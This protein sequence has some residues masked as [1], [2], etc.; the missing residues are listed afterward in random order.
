[1]ADLAGVRAADGGEEV[2]ED[3][4]RLEKVELAVELD[5][6]RREQVPAE[7]GHRHVVVPE[8]ALIRQIVDRED[9]GELAEARRVAVERAEVDGDEA[10]LPV[11][12]VNDLWPPGAPPRLPDQRQ[13]FE[14]AAAE[15]DK[16][17]AVVPVVAVGRPVEALAVE[18]LVVTEKVHGN[19]RGRPALEE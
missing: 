6:G 15:E 13:R 7:P 1:S 2:R 19:V 12:A 3:Q 14:P 11:I 5:P 8:Y 9:R 17:L 10:G 4:S 16:A 18:V